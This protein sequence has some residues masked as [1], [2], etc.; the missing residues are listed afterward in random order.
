[1]N[2]GTMNI[3]V[4]ESRSSRIA[5]PAHRFDALGDLHGRGIRTIVDLSTARP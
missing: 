5:L 2:A 4:H 3:N 1:M